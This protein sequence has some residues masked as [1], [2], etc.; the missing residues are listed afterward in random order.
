MNDEI[1]S[2]PYNTR[3]SFVSASY[4]THV[5][6]VFVVAGILRGFFVL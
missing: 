3:Y 5:Y 1:V 6:G 2:V 4:N